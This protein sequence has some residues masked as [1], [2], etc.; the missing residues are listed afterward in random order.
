MDL[1]RVTQASPTNPIVGDLELSPDGDFVWLSPSDSNYLPARVAQS[2][3]ARLAFPKATWYL[4][5][6]EGVPYLQALLGLKGIPDSTWRAVF[7]EVV[8]GTPGIATLDYLRATRRGREITLD[9][10]ARLANGKVF[11]SADSGPFTVSTGLL[12]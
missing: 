8:L 3:R 7:R 6:N 2:L 1:K 10:R 12:G 5:K 9:I 11:S 4:N